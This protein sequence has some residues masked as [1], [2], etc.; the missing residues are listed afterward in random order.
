MR[1]KNGPSFITFTPEMQ[2][3]ITPKDF[4]LD[5]KQHNVTLELFIDKYPNTTQYVINVTIL[6]S[7]PRFDNPLED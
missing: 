6:N 5:M 2:M 4:Y 3:K 1:V 7:L